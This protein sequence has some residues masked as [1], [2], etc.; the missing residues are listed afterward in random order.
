MPVIQDY[1]FLT[2]RPMNI[3]SDLENARCKGGEKIDISSKA[4]IAIGTKP[5]LVTNAASRLFGQ[6]PDETAKQAKNMLEGNLK[7]TIMGFTE[8]QLRNDPEEFVKQ[9]EE[10]VEEGLNKLG[11]TIIDI[12]IDYSMSGA[13]R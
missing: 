6:R 4:T 12:N 10:K 7:K 2:L 5:E 1:G 13:D 3:S 8:D 11:I 9:A